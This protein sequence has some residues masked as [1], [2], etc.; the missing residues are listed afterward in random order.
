MKK[1][2]DSYNDLEFCTVT[3]NDSASMAYIKGEPFY[4]S[5]EF[6]FTDLDNIVN[7]NTLKELLEMDGNGLISMKLTE[8]NLLSQGWIKKP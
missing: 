7:V 3:Y 8:E 2:Y 6:K 4:I 1:M 5:V